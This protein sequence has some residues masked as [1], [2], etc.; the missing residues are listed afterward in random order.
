MQ[1][2]RKR[3]AA[4]SAGG[5]ARSRRLS[6]EQRTDIAKRAAEAR[7]RELPLAVCGQP[8]RPLRIGAA[9]IPCYVL[10]DGTRVLTQAGFLGAMGRHPKANVRREEGEEGLP[11]IL[12]G[13]SI[14]PFI[15]KEIIEKSTPVRFRTPGGSVA[16]GY[17]A[18]LLPDVCEV[19]LRAR[20]AGA[21]SKHQEHIARQA[22]VLV[23]GLATVGIIALVDEATGYQEFRA[24]SALAQI[25]ERFIA[26]EL[27]AWVQTFP[28]DYYQHLFRLRGLDFHKDSPKRPQYFGVLTND[29]VYKRLAPGVLEELKRVTT[30][31]ESGRPTHKYFQRLTSNVGYP[32]LREHLGT[33]V[34]IMKLSGGWHDFMAKLDRIA[35]RFGSTLAL[36]FD[37]Y[38]AAA[39]PGRG[40]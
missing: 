22:E 11:P 28:A 14:N 8:D 5:F 24:K 25:L 29:I 2:D 19:Y 33:V 21:L 7:W 17:R 36:P 4:Q 10:D 39:D 13:R 6:P 31:S 40:M 30:R 1:R 18:E 3:V 35:P 32:S 27:Q 37:D 26:K 12:Q 20:D 23:R 34:A 16:S 15:S 9:E 38:E